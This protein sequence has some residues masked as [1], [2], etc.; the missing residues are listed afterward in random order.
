MPEQDHVGHGSADIAYHVEWGFRREALLWDGDA[1]VGVNFH[2]LATEL[3]E[4]LQRRGPF[5]VFAEEHRAIPGAYTNP[6]TFD[7]STLITILASVINDSHAIATSDMPGDPLETEVARVR[8]YNE[9]C[10]YVVRVCE[11]LIKQLLHCTQIP[12]RYYARASLGSLLSTECRGCR[13]SGQQRHKLSLLGSLAHRYHLCHEFEGCLMQ[14]LALAG[15]RRNTSAAH[16]AVPSLNIRSAAES[17]RQLMED[18]VALGN[19]FVHMLGHLRNLET[20][21][22]NELRALQQE[23]AVATW[24]PRRSDGLISGMKC[25][26]RG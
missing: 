19:E 9:Q 13:N 7:A 25:S 23:S 14:H 10:L 20:R 3:Y 16:S 4:W 22:D 11:A 26:L 6:F 8:S 18:S 15:R 5:T 1:P 21:M 17:R 2:P 12:R 24:E